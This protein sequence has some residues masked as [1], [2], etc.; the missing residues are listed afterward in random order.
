MMKF[1]GSSSHGNPSMNNGKDFWDSVYELDRHRISERNN[2]MIIGIIIGAIGG[3]I[4]GIAIA[5]PI[6]Y[7]WKKY[8]K[9]QETP[10]APPA[11]SAQML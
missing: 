9:N 8:H 1:S 4:F 11:Y 6:F 2:G 7:A 5:K 3:T 10:T